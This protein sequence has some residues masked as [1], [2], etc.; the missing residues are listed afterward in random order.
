VP[1]HDHFAARLGALGAGALR[2]QAL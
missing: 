1:G 2:D